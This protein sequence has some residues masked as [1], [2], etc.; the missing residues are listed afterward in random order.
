MKKIILIKFG[1]SIITDKNVPYKAR[2]EVIRRLAQELKKI[3]NVSV[4]LAHGNGSFGHTSS[5]KF[6]G[7]KGYR[8][9]WGIA[10]VAKDVMELNR[11]V[12]NILVDEGLSAIS[13]RPMSMILTKEAKIESSLFEIVEEVLKQGLIPVLPGDIIWDKKWKSTIY[14][15]ETVLNEIG[16]Y[17]KKKGFTINKIIQVGETN[18]VYDNE[19][20]TIKL[21]N[22]NNWRD[23]QK[24]VFK[25]K[26]ADISGGMKHKIETALYI[27]NKGIE[28]WITSGVISNEF[29]YALHGKKGHATIVA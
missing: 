9:K 24:F 28:T 26:R 15:G 3:K 10:K 22:K 14:S 29:R 18:G 6:G 23:L 12:V 25:N 27:A 8:S 2:P 5:K 11:I 20:K 13:L 16:L 1:G 17:L 4:V 19:G 21:I 7:K